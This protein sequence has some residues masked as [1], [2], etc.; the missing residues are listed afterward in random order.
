VFVLPSLYEGF[1]IVL[2]E[3]MAAGLPIVASKTGGV[4]EIVADGIDG[5]LVNPGDSDV[6]A[7]AIS[8]IALDSDLSL[9]FAINAK[10]NVER[11]SL[12]KML[13]GYF[14]LYEN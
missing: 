12:D 4:P 14:K 11:Y 3:A 1:G 10:R 13:K 9:E 7:D 6:L 5:C 8:H 2:L